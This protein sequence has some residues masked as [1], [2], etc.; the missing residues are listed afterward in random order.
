MVFGRVLRL[1]SWLFCSVG[2]VVWGLLWLR[3]GVVWVVS[4]LCFYA[5]FVVYACFMHVLCMWVSVLSGLYRGVAVFLC[6][7]VGFMQFLVF[8]A[9]L[10]GGVL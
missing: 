1:V 6:S 8:Y 9:V 10:L 3:F 2:G 5:C 4:V 7:L